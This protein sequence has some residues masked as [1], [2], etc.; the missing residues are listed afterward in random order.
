MLNRFAFN[1]LV[2]ALL[3]SG[4]A[5]AQSTPQSTAQPPAWPAA[6][7]AGLVDAETE[8]QIDALLARLTLEEKVGQLIQADISTVRP[9]DLK[10]YPFGSVLAGGN[11]PP[12]GAP[13]RSGLAP[14]V[15]TVRAFRAAAAARPGG[16]HIPLLFGIDAVHGNNN[17]VGATLFPH[18]IGLGAMRDPAL[19]RKIGRAT[20]RETA[21]SGFDWAFAPTLAVPRDDR[22]GRS[23]EGY[24]ED[25]EIVRSYAGEIVLGLQGVM[26]KDARKGAIQQGHVAA[27]AKHFLGDGGTFDGDDQGDSRVSEDDLI[28]LH[29]QGYVP[30][31][32]A[33]AL[34]IM[35][36]FSSWNGEKMHGNRSLLTDVLKGRMGFDGLVVG[37]WD[38]H[39]QI[40]GCTPTS[41]ARAINAGLDMFMSPEGWRA[42]FDN[43]LAQ[44]RS[45][46]ILPARLDDEVRRI[47]RVKFKLGLFQPARP[48]EG[49]DGVLGR[50]EHRAL[51]RQAVRRSLVLL[52]NSAGLLPLRARARILVAGAGADDIGRQ[53]GGWTLSWQGEGNS[54]RDFP[55]AQSI[56]AGIKEALAQAGGSATLSVDG[57]FKS[58]PDAA[59]VV[60]GEPPYAE[61]GGDL[62]TLEYQPGDKT[63]LALIKRLKAAGVPVVAVFLSGR[64]L[65]VNPELNA[66][67]AFVA[68]WLPGSEGGGVADLLIGDAAGKPRHDFHGALSFSWPMSAAQTSL[69]RGD[70]NY[71]PLFAY[72]YGLRYRDQQAPWQPLSEVSGVSAPSANV[73]DFFVDGRTPAP[74][75][76]RLSPVG[77]VLLHAVDA[78][79]IQEAGRE[80]SF[81]GSGLATAALASERP[82]DLRL[83]TQAD[84]ALQID[85]RLDARPSAP[86]SVVMDGAR[87]DLSPLLAAVPLGEWRSLKLPLKC[88]QAAGADVTKLSAPFA[89][90]T[91]GRL[92][93]SV[94]SVKLTADGGAATCLARAG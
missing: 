2:C 19:M 22:W 41:C 11:S 7:S 28:R 53:S 73:S 8:A 54:N 79:G 15:G 91:S 78:D 26:A 87:L 6:K 24:S 23:Y 66:A 81:L 55:G 69:N 36:S 47:L 50:A 59:V 94:K 49:R 9:E 27:S 25:P 80:I 51:A 58:R 93:L 38:G 88:F 5:H 1:A 45:G 20:A 76:F 52:K 18:N 57:S 64:P 83:Q 33:G 46:E 13:D 92:T 40:K 3:L 42:L 14:W 60:F 67:D 61:G 89:V 63:D 82:I 62:K 10:I 31:I 74:F 16:T 43:T 77:G 85:Y 75:A 12:L 86:V 72:G 37:D 44:A 65:W 32:E 35:A 71:A 39:G 30:A 70:K 48:W 4:G 68:A 17:V 34:T 29:A 21:A 84:M 90:A 56:F